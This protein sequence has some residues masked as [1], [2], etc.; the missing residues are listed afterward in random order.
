MPTVHPPLVYYARR[1]D[2]IKIGTTTQIKRRLTDQ[3]FDELLAVEPGSFDLE[4]QRHVQ[5]GGSLANKRRGQNEWFHPGETLLAH[6]KELRAAHELPDLSTRDCPRLDPARQDLLASLPPLVMDV[7]RGTVERFVSKIFIDEASGCIR[8]PAGADDNGYGQFW[9][10]GTMHRSHR[11]S[12]ILFIGPIPDGYDVDHVK[13]RGCR[14]RDCVRPSHLEAVTKRENT[15]RTYVPPADGNGPGGN[16]GARNA[17]VTHCP[18]DHEYTPENTYMVGKNKDRR[19][20]KI[21]TKAKAMER[22]HRLKNDPAYQE[23]RRVN[24]QAFRK[25]RRAAG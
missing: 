12:H 3:A 15:M 10:E 17:N 24:V 8:R 4:W 9:F 13:D 2:L 19:Q 16:M 22:H 23:Q 11:V 1:G 18:E 21:C 25:R 6:I 20:C 5:F 7:R 14:F